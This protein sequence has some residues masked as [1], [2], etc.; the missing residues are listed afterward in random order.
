MDFCARVMV[1]SVVQGALQYRRCRR[2]TGLAAR[3]KPGLGLRTARCSSRSSVSE[4][5]RL[6]LSM[7]VCRVFLGTRQPAW[8]GVTVAAMATEVI[9]GHI[10]TQQWESM[11]LL[12]HTVSVGT[13]AVVGTHCCNSGNRGNCWDTLL[14]QWH[15]FTL[16]Q[17]WPWIRW[18]PLFFLSSKKVHLS[19][20]INEATCWCH[21]L[22]CGVKVQCTP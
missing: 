15:R 7:Y 3:R 8:P 4:E 16:S 21:R 20:V 2:T 18:L 17:Q 13:Q 22:C 5:H 6:G 14:P 10:V 19:R 11:H 1:W 9:L 12:E